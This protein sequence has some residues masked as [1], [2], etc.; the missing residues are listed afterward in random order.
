M[1]LRS[2]YV[3]VLFVVALGLL[4]LD[5]GRAQDPAPQPETQPSEGDSAA[6]EAPLK[7]I[8]IEKGPRIVF[9][10]D[11]EKGATAWRPREDASWKL[12][13]DAGSQVY[14][15]FVHSTAIEPPHRSPY[16]MSL[17]KD[18]VV[19]NFEL[20]VR[21]R[22]TKELYNHRDVCVFFGFQDPA[23]FY[24]VHF[25][26]ATD[27]HAN[28]IFIVNAADRIKISTKTTEGTPWD[29]AWHTVRI[30]RGVETGQI[31][32]YFDDMENPI[33]TAVDRNFTWG[34]VGVGS[35]D[36]M[37]NWDDFRLVASLAQRPAETP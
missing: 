13:Q 16:N 37:A 22:A 34:Q 5:A 11:F 12:D 31:A 10:D 24:Y 26:Q 35:F 32:V 8:A 1:S 21:V 25:G 6:A 28:Q 23:H 30:V 36:D 27:D 20:T 14:S 17:V 19:G 15:Q 9:Q 2:P 7:T 18:L 3:A 33:M 4:L 29:D